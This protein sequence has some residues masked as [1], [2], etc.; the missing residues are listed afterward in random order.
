MARKEE[1]VKEKFFVHCNNCNAKLECKKE[2]SPIKC[3]A[4]KKWGAV[5]IYNVDDEKVYAEVYLCN[6]CRHE[7]WLKFLKDKKA[8]TWIK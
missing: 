2:D 1:E 5:R 6:D 7:V 8:K 3:M 4:A